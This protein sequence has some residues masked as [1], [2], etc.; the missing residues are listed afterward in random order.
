LN[1]LADGVGLHRIEMPPTVVLVKYCQL[2]EQ[3]LE[4]Y[5]VE[6]QTEV[7]AIMGEYFLS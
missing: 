1:L 5:P 6:E 7:V 2:W 3:L 4:M